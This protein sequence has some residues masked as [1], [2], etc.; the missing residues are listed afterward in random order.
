MNDRET[1]R[2]THVDAARMPTDRP[3]DRDEARGVT[4]GWRDYLTSH[5]SLVI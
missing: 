1:H 2:C 3:T 4:I 5:D